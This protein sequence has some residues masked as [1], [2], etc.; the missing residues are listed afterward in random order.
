M[1]FKVILNVNWTLMFKNNNLSLRTINQ[2]ITTLVKSASWTFNDVWWRLY[3]FILIKNYLILAA[4]KAWFFQSFLYWTLFIGSIFVFPFSLFIWLFFCSNFT[5][6]FQSSSVSWSCFHR[7][8]MSLS[9]SG[10]PV[11]VK[12][13]GQYC[14]TLLDTFSSYPIK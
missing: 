5:F 8:P 3:Y 2:L 14:L 10:K 7:F 4:K 13:V 6:T 11:I 9:F 1:S 12:P